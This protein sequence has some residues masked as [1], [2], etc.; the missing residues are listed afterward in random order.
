MTLETTAPNNAGDIITA[1]LKVDNFTDIV[2][3]Q[4][5]MNWDPNELL[6]L[7]WAT[8]D[9]LIYRMAILEAIA[10]RLGN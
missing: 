6:F 8:L 3:M 10:V 9:Y 4:I 7:G 5:S 1:K 2:S